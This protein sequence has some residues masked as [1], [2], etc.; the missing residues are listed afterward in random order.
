LVLFFDDTNLLRF[1]FSMEE[2]PYQRDL[3]VFRPLEMD[4][5]LKKR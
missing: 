1:P 3:S 4:H 2:K 5:A